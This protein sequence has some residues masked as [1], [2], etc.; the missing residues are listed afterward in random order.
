M[1]K[2]FKIKKKNS[3]CYELLIRQ[4]GIFCLSFDSH[5]SFKQ[6]I[7]IFVNNKLKTKVLS[8]NK[9]KYYRVLNL[10]IDDILILELE[11]EN[12]IKNI[13]LTQYEYQNKLIE[14]EKTSDTKR[15]LMGKSFKN[16]FN[17]KDKTSKE[18]R[19][20]YRNI[21]YKSVLKTSNIYKLVNDITILKNEYK[22]ELFNGNWW[23]YEIGIPLDLLSFFRLNYTKININL[24]LEYFDYF[25]YI[26]FDPNYIYFAGL[27][28]KE[29][30]TGANFID[31]LEIKI[32]KY[33]FAN[34]LTK[35]E[36]LYKY[37]S[38]KLNYVKS[39]DGFYRDGS[40]I[41]HNNFAYNG[42]YGIDSLCG[43]IKL[44]KVYKELN[45]LTKKD[46]KF[47]LEIIENSFLPFIY[48]GMFFD[49]LRGRAISR[50]NINSKY[51]Y[52]LLQENID[53]FY[54]LLNLNKTEDDIYGLFKFDKM[55]RYLVKNKEF[56][57]SLSFS[58]EDIYTHESING[59]NLNGYYYA[60]GSIFYY[61][62]G[63]DIYKEFYYPT[64]DY[65]YVC[66]VTNTDKPLSL[67]LKGKPVK[68]KVVS[69]KKENDIFISY[70]Y[71]NPFDKV[72][73]NYSYYYFKDTLHIIGSNIKSCSKYNLY[74]TVI[75]FPELND[76]NIKKHENKI[77]IN[78]KYIYDI[79]IGKLKHKDYI[80]SGSFNKININ[81]D[82]K[83][84]KKKYLLSYIDLN[85]EN[86]F[87]YTFKSNEGKKFDYIIENDYHFIKS[88]NSYIL[89]IFK[90]N[91]NIKIGN[92]TY[93]NKGIYFH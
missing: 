81:E 4:T 75:N 35:I 44:S 59:E 62:K 43:I 46:E 92:K 12:S 13:C 48:D 45:L 27:K 32:Y 5:L 89:S 79:Y 49:Q 21:L 34:D 76:L 55:K 78:N 22:K 88:N 74:H 2:I 50:K 57:L 10:K 77:Y 36:K 66:G 82:N 30:S 58:D 60:L 26:T 70:K 38:K 64:I 51:I 31:L 83:L 15:A 40:F 65:R 63:I 6:N 87:Y 33:I 53:N 80:G 11:K 71:I 73:G 42:S 61:F 72:S 93:N 41:Q 16:Y 85:N 8:H 3:K 90:D 23:D 54:K 84:Y 39:G 52:N 29:K 7:N 18:L 56:S 9:Q 91:L 47:I 17:K 28:E 86:K 25:D 68:G 19:S 20:T 24:I 69:L 1:N 37:F 14:L 67:G